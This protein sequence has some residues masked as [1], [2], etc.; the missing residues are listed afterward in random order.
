MSDHDQPVA[1]NL[2]QQEFTAER[3]NQRWVGDTSELRIGDT[4]KAYLAVVRDL[5]SRFVVG[6]AVGAVNDRHLTI[7]ALDMAVKRRCPAVGLLHH[8]D[9]GSTYASEDYQAVLEAHGITCSMS[10]RGNCYD[11]AVMEAFFSTV[12]NEVGE[13]FASH[14][15]AKAEL[16]V[17][18]ELF[19]NQRRRHSSAGRMSPAAFERRTM[20]AA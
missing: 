16:F 11:N 12:K 20:Q 4:G 15:D 17:Y 6:W 5:F 14:A 9:Q 13:R 8:S 10:R 7:K 2:L 1:A 19:Y 3:P 18:I